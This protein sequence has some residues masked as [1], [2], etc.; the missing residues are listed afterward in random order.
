MAEKHNPADTAEAAVVANAGL[1]DQ[2]RLVSLADR[3]RSQMIEFGVRFQP[4]QLA[5]LINEVSATISTAAL[6]V[7][8][9]ALSLADRVRSQMIEFGARAAAGD[10]LISGPPERL[11]SLLETPSPPLPGGADSRWRRAA[12]RRRYGWF[13]TGRG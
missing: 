11:S 2:G 8:G 9:G 4:G 6:H 1:Y 5:S 10:T 13:P 7:S 3:V 12:A